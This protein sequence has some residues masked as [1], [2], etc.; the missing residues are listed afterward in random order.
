[1]NFSIIFSVGSWGGFY[2]HWGFSK[3]ICLGWVA[4]TFVPRDIDEYAV[5]WLKKDES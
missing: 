4:F 5:R 3:R 1:M 2:L